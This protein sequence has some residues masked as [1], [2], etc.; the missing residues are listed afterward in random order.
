MGKSEVGKIG[1]EKAA[2]YLKKQGYKILGRNWKNSFGYRLGEIDIIAKDKKEI[3]FV[4]VKTRVADDHELLNILPEEQITQPKLHK[5]DRIAV[6][7]LN[8][9][10]LRSC[11][12]RFDAVS[13][14][15]DS[16]LKQAK[17]KHLKSIFI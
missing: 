6:C 5:L 7:Y 13:V 3:V 1:E 16:D 17:I 11:P 14:W 15:L 8:S 9:Q 10:K 2:R 12:Y 4:E